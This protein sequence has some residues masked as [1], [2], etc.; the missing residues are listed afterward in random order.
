VRRDTDAVTIGSGFVL[1]TADGDSSVMIARFLP[2][3]RRVHVGDTVDWTAQDPATPHTVTFGPAPANRAA[4]I[5]FVNGAA[6]EPTT[7]PGQTISSGF[8]GA[9]FPRQR[10]T[11]TFNAPGTYDYYCAV[12]PN[13][14]AEVMVM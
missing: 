7:P 14:Q 6:V 5:G 10:V 1:T 13:M 2:G 12:H 8:L 4:V 3:T 9:P 11:V